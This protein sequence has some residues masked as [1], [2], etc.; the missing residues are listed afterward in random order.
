VI[1]TT[2]VCQ[3]TVSYQCVCERERERERAVSRYSGLTGQKMQPAVVS[4]ALVY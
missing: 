3:V 4:A 2:F 1:S